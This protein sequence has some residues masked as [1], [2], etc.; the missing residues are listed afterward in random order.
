[1]LICGCLSMVLCA[2]LAAFTVAQNRLV[3]EVELRGYQSVSR[4]ELLQ[5]IKTKPGELYVAE[6]VKQDL[7]ALLATGLFDKLRSKVVINTGPRGGVV[8]TFDL[9][10]LPK[11]K[12]KQ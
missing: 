7:S 6:Q 10:E 2:G 4:E 12:P 5:K 1:M 3:E 9:K 8:V 11:A